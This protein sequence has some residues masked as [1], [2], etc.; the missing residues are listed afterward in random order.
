MHDSVLGMLNLGENA[1]PS[2]GSL[3][4]LRGNKIA[5]LY[6][7]NIKSKQNFQKALWWKCHMFGHCPLYL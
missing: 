4:L 2:G 6:F 1:K 5:R 3:P 7:G